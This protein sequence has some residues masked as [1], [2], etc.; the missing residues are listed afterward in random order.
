MYKI[1]PLKKINLKQEKLNLFVEIMVILFLN[2]EY[3]YITK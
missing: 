3:G 2:A 1:I